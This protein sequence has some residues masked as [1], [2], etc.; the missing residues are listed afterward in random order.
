MSMIYH[1]F[2]HIHSRTV[3]ESV[4]Q[5]FRVQPEACILVCAP[6]NPATD[7]LVSRLQKSLQRHEMLRL[8]APNRT[9]A[10][11]PDSIMQ[12]CCERQSAAQSAPQI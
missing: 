9:F 4:L 11:V 2:V 3:V 12:Y 10:E 1:F 6:S 7:T 5:I 8:N